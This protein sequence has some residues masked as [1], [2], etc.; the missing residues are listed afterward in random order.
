MTAPVRRSTL[1]STQDVGG[2]AT[3][4][5]PLNALIWAPHSVVMQPE[6]SVE[7]RRVS[8]LVLTSTKESAGRPHVRHCTASPSHVA[9]IIGMAR[10]SGSAGRMKRLVSELIFISPFTSTQPCEAAA[11]GFGP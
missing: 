2:S 11:I 3:T 8:P 7:L 1:E 9:A 10:S 6:A 5:V 4:T